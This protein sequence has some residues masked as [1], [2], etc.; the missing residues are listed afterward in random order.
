MLYLRHLVPEIVEM[1]KV[2]VVDTTGDPTVCE[3]FK[4]RVRFWS[5][6]IEKPSASHSDSA[7]GDGADLTFVL[8][9][10]MLYT[11]GSR[12][13][14]AVRDA[15]RSVPMVLIY[16]VARERLQRVDRRGFTR[17]RLQA[18]LFPWILTIL[19]RLPAPIRR[20]FL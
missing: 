19:R 11:R 16:D 18:M 5:P 10:E 20:A 9:R 8:H 4:E 13:V 15:L 7:N 3:D 6:G 2:S 17:F 1:K 12:L 14:T